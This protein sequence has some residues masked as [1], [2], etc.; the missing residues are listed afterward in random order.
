MGETM[1]KAGKDVL[2]STSRR[3]QSLRVVARRDDVYGASRRRPT[4]GM[5]LGLWVG[6]GSSP[7][8][9]SLEGQPPP[10]R[11]RTSLN[12]LREP[13]ARSER[14]ARR[15]DARRSGTRPRDYAWERDG[16]GRARARTD[17]GR[18]RAT[19]AHPHQSACESCRRRRTI[20][21]CLL[22]YRVLSSCAG[23]RCS[24]EGFVLGPGPFSSL[25]GTI[26]LFTRQLDV[27]AAI[28][29]LHRRYQLSLE[30]G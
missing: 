19:E 9:S 1:N 3:R 30:L 24:V 29:L 10:S 26:E 6:R 11:A 12:H 27:L 15:R 22:R 13:A 16:R 14:Q 28:D 5:I 4:I 18:R 17:F 20:E 7:S 23:S 21:A 25:G 8:R 2:T